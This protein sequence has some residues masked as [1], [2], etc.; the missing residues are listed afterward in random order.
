M[1]HEEISRKGGAVKSLAKLAAAN[2]NL[3]KAARD[4]SPAELFFGQSRWWN[5]P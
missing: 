1:T 2:H 4:H 3:A 5:C